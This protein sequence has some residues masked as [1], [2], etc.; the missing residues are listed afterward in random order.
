MP[1]SL[2]CVVPIDDPKSFICEEVGGVLIHILPCQLGAARSVCTLSSQGEG[3]EV[4]ILL[5]TCLGR[6]QNKEVREIN[7]Q[8]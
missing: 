5:L 3:G 8:R 2:G 6:K 1:P 4:W 7:H